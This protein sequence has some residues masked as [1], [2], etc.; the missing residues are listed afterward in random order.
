[1]TRRTQTTALLAVLLLC[2]CELS[3]SDSTEEAAALINRSRELMDIRAAGSPPFM[4]RARVRVTMARGAVIWRQA[5]EGNYELIWSSP[6]RWREEVRFP[7]FIQARVG[8]E[9]KFW[10]QRSVDYLPPPV[11][12]LL[13]T[14]EMRP[15]LR[16]REGEKV[17]KIRDRKSKATKLRCVELARKGGTKRELCVELERGVLIREVLGQG[18]YEY[19]DYLTLGNRVFPRVIRSAGGPM[20]AEIEVEELVELPSVDGS[21]FKPPS[22]AQ[23][24]G[25]CPDPVRPRRLTD[26]G[27]ISP[28]DGSRS[29]IVAYATIDA[30]G[31]LAN[32]KVLSTTS[33]AFERTMLEVWKKVRYQ[34]QTCDGVPVETETI[35]WESYWVQ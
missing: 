1:M 13:G 9:G 25:W 2:C 12:E 23:A 8:D 4:L 28:Q 22:Q 27:I 5:F 33:P 11:W 29:E 7:G 30:D 6:T 3:A 19:E 24:W 35:L 17:K 31:R 10:Q 16:L 20:G 32:I 26:T 14:L 34:P 21:L 15:R 18:K